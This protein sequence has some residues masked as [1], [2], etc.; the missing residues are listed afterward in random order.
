LEIGWDHKRREEGLVLKCVWGGALKVSW[1][2]VPRKKQT[3]T[4][5]VGVAILGVIIFVFEN[6]GWIFRFV[7]VVL[8]L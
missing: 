1:G 3:L 5:M 6:V 4:G 8:G 2:R 7:K